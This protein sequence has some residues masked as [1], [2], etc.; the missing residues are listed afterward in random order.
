MARET[1]SL[2]ITEI[3]DFRTTPRHSPCLSVANIVDDR[4]VV[5]IGDVLGEASLPYVLANAGGYAT[6]TMT[7]ADPGSYGVVS[8]GDNDDLDATVEMPAEPPTDRGN[9]GWYAFEPEVFDSVERT[10]VA[11][12][13]LRSLDCT[14]ACD[15]M[16]NQL[17]TLLQ[18]T[19]A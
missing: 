6:A 7:V 17:Q 14:T 10:I 8:A 2:V 12:V 11:F 15:R 18:G 9:V 13:S 1:E 16:C 19:R 5:L 3:F 4:F